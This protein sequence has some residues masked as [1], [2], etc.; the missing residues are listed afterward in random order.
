MKKDDKNELQK[1]SE[2][3][4]HVL[5]VQKISK[6]INLTPMVCTFFKQGQVGRGELFYHR[7]PST[8]IFINETAYAFSGLHCFGLLIRWILRR[9]FQLAA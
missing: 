3:F 6:G 9:F 8:V 2:L 4:K 5:A 1:L 7:S